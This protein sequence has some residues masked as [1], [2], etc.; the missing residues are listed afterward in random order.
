MRARAATSTLVVAT[1]F[2]TL[3]VASIVA[4]MGVSWYSRALAMAVAL[5]FMMQTGS[6]HPP[7]AAAI[8]AFMDQNVLQ[9]LGV[10][11]VAY[12][13]LLGSLFILTMGRLCARL[14]RKHEFVL[15]FR[16][17]GFGRGKNA[18]G[19]ERRKGHPVLYRKSAYGFKKPPEILRELAARDAI[20]AAVALA[21]PRSLALAV[22]TRRSPR[23]YQDETASPPPQNGS[24]K[25][26]SLKPGLAVAVA[27][28][29]ALALGGRGRHCRGRRR[30]R[31]R[32]HHGRCR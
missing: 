16:W 7:G 23:S 30:C 9:E 25:P 5:A 28:G 6:V 27:V 24:E 31:G 22:C 1:L 4:A 17:R 3:A 20:P 14:K 18:F 29:I 10:F 32:R 11:Y 8:M 13:V 21:A 2:S 15:L 26:G 12:P 19:F